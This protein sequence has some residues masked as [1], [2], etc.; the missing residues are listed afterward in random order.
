MPDHRT[1]AQE[2]LL[3]TQL[4]FQQIFEEGPIGMAMEGADLKY[5][6]ANAAFCRMLG[7]TESELTRLT[8]PEVTLPEYAPHEAETA[9]RLMSGE[10]LKYSTE[11]RYIKKNGDIIWAASTISSIRDT[12]GHFIYFLVIVEDI[13]ERKN[14]ETAL[15]KSEEAFRLLATNARDVIYRMSL[16]D[17]RYEYV[18]PAAKN[19]MGYAPEEIYASP[20]LI[21][22][23][24][25]PQ[26]KGYFVEQ[27]AKLLAGDVPPF[28]EYQIVNRSGQLRWLRQSNVLL[29][30]AAGRPSALEG[31]VTDITEQKRTQ[32]ELFEARR[33]AEKRAREAE[34]GRRTLSAIIENYPEGIMIVDTDGAIRM[35]NK[36][37]S[38]I[39]GLTQETVLGKSMDI[40]DKHLRQGEMPREYPLRQVLRRGQ[41]VDNEEWGVIRL[42]GERISVVITA[43][44]VRDSAGKL[45][46]AMTTWQDITQRKRIEDQLRRSEY[47]LRTLVNNSPDL[48]VRFDRRMRYVYANPAYERIGGIAREHLAGKTNKEL[49]MPEEQTSYWESAARKVFERGREESVEFDFTGF[50]GKRYLWG[51][52]IPEFAKDGSVETVITISRDITERK[53]AEEQVRYISFHDEVTGLFNRSYFEEEIRRIDTERELPISIIMSDVNNL[54]LTNDVFG[55]DEG[56]KLL[57][58]IAHIL[59]RACRKNDVIARWGGDEFTVILPRTDPATAKEVCERIVQI[60]KGSRDT[61]IAPS[62]GTG[63]AVKDNKGQNIYRVLRLAEERMYQN[64]LDESRHIEDE[65]Y[66]ALLERA[67]EKNK[68]LGEH[69]ARSG[70]LAENFGKALGLTEKQMD[71]LRLLIKLHDI[72]DVVIPRDILDKPGL[73]TEQEWGIMKKHA[74]AGF[75]IVKTFTDTARIAEE[76]LF[77]GERWDGIGYPRGLRGT[78]IPYLARVFSIIDAYDVMTHPRPYGPARSIEDADNELRRMAG[79]QFD[80][81]LV[82]VFIDQVIST[83][84]T[85]LNR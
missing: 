22:Q 72:G 8:F 5:I 85:T 44:P 55:H 40:I 1:S 77:H 41:P 52:I 63:M 78:K 17:G 15:R 21:R 74:E 23:I 80:P 71:D 59:R 26:W 42:N 67:C 39:I 48:I 33:V 82:E 24:I 27:W 46:S 56:D 84:V 35:L 32:Q 75:R 62:L 28:Y 69:I 3:D 61:I 57:K 54:K 4:L 53:H 66:A 30:N 38:M 49:G 12:Q 16:P 47:E 10:Q 81:K 25:A 20:L 65:T 11:K 45:I 14:A 13:S 50:F 36:H 43:V 29:R 6:R 7:Y 19:I 34:D 2:I 70:I 76:V 37:M 51:K 73:L 83:Y 18:S 31:I 64:K 60:S 79:K 58:T 68:G 9:Q